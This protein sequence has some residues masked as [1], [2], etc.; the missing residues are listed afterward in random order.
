MVNTTHF[1]YQTVSED[2]KV[3]KVAEVFYRR[4]LQKGVGRP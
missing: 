3:H 4:W 2:A 1:G